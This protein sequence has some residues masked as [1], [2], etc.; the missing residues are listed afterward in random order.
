MS[1]TER[2]KVLVADDLTTSRMLIIDALQELGFRQILYAPNG[3]EALKLAMSNTVHLII[4]DFEM[5]GL[6]GVAF[7]QS[8]RSYAPTRNV[9]FVLVTG[10]GDKA[11]IE[12]ARKF[13]L[14]NYVAKP[15][16][17]PTLKAAIKAVIGVV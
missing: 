17:V 14:N 4:S 2:V 7:L 12:R 15:F 16:T 6:D 11:L 9:P 10:R 3:A 5:P 1:L 8:V 13:G